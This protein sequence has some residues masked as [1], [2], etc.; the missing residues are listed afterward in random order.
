MSSLF[1]TVSED[2]LENIKR[3]IKNLAEIKNKLYMT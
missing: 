3:N 2:N 1:G